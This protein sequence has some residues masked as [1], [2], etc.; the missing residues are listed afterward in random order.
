MSKAPTYSIDVMYCLFPFLFRFFA[1]GFVE[2]VDEVDL[3]AVGHRDERGTVGE[4][5]RG[6]LCLVERGPVGQTLAVRIA[7]LGEVHPILLDDL[8]NGSLG[9]ILVGLGQEMAV[10]VED[11]VGMGD[12]TATLVL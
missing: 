2:T 3:I 6:G 5:H 1:L 7:G 10:Q 4:L 9:R 12:T 11:V 8:C